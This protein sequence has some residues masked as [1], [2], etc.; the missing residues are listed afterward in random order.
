MIRK[1]AVSVKV[2]APSRGLVTRL[3]PNIA[4]LST[5]QQSYSGLTIGDANRAVVVAQNMR[6]EDG[7][8]C[9]APGYEQVIMSGAGLLTDLL[10]HWTMD[11]ASG[12][13]SDSLGVWNLTDPTTAI[14]TGPNPD[15][16]ALPGGNQ[17][18]FSGFQIVGVPGVMGNAANISVGQQFALTASL[19]GGAPSLSGGD[20][21][22]AFWI[23]PSKYSWT[24]GSPNTNIIQKVGSVYFYEQLEYAIGLNNNAITFSTTAGASQQTINGVPYYAGGTTVTATGGAQITYGSW[25]FVVVRFTNSSGAVSI[26]VNGNAPVSTT[27]ASL[28][29]VGIPNMGAAFSVGPNNT[30]IACAYD[31]MSMWSRALSDAEVATLYNSGSGSEYPWL[32]GAF[33]LCYQGNVI[34]A[35]PTPTVFGSG[36]ALYLGTKTFQNNTYNLALQPLITECNPLPGYRWT[37][38]SFVDKVVCALNNTTPQ[39]WASGLTTSLPI[40]GLTVGASTFDGVESFFGHLIYWSGNTLTWSALNDHTNYVPVGMTGDTLT[41]TP[42]SGFTQPSLAAPT[43]GVVT[44]TVPALPAD[45]AGGFYRVDDSTGTQTATT[46]F[47]QVAAASKGA[48]SITATLQNMTGAAQAG[49]AFPNTTQLVPLTA[50]EAGSATVVGSDANGPVLAVKTVGDYAYIFK[51]RSISSMQYVGLGNGIFY[52]HTEVTNEGLIAPYAFV[53]LGNGQLIFLGQRELYQYT[54]GANLTP[55]CRQ[56]T[57][58]LFA[59][60]DRN[61][62]QQL[63]VAHREL[64]NEIWVVYPALGGVLKVL[65]WNYMEDTASIDIYDPSIQG[66]AAVAMMDW[67]NDPA[68]LAL[69]DVDTWAFYGNELSWLKMAGQGNERVCVMATGDSNLRI[70]GKVYDRNGAS[71][72]CLAETKDFDFDNDAAFK[73]VDVVNLA[74]Q[75]LSPSGAP[76]NLYVQVGYRPTLDADLTWTTPKAIQVQGNA[77]FTAK[78]NPGGAGR[79][80]RLR[81]YSQDADVQWRLSGYEIYARLGGTY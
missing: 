18:L 8:M 37:A 20:F 28:A 80:I 1:G 78:I 69:S 2:K 7:V 33:N 23:K 38:T 14:Q 51:A 53:N 79:Y 13:R 26:Q 15:Q 68:W 81:F 47:Y 67:T 62:L 50:N 52:I 58:Q 5:F 40:P 35:Q 12:T 75:V 57:R 17:T 9:N 25:N 34:G 71:Y 54:G 32:G 11:E 10:A 4:D 73:Y 49:Y 74:L 41:I 76:W 66:V 43:N 6:F 19:Y 63:I 55:V 61:N 27:F 56:Y 31:S 42:T 39:Y 45:I 21:T 59:E 60:L 30:Q 64:R 16:I 36:S 44:I 3:P 72:I 48:T 65:V 24:F 22:I 29:N 46:S 77:N 70:H